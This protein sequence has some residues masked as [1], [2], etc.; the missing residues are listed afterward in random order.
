MGSIHVSGGKILCGETTIQGSKNAA[1]PLMAAAV[2]HKGM[3]VLHN[4]PV[5]QDVECMRLLLEDLGCRTG[6]EGHT[7]WIDASEI[8]K[9][10]L[11]AGLTAKMR[12][13]VLLMGALL[14]RCQEVILPFPG[15]CVIGKRPVNYHLDVM[16]RMGAEVICREDQMLLRARKLEGSETE[17]PFPSVG[18]TENGILAGTLAAGRSCLSGCAMEPEIQELCSFLRE[19]GA[20]VRMQG[21]YVSME[22]VRELHDSE[23]ILMP[24]RIVAGTYLLAVLATNGNAILHEVPVDALHVLKELIHKMG[25]GLTEYDQEKQ[26]RKWKTCTVR[27]DCRKRKRAVL[28]AETAPYPGFPTDLQSQLMAVMASCDGSTCRI[29]E[30]VFENRFMIVDQLK[31]M[32]ADIREKENEAYIYGVP[33]LHGTD[34]CVR[35]MR[36]GAALVLAAM[37]AE[38]VSRIGPED[39]IK[40]GYE[41][42]CKDLKELGADMN[43]KE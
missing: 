9:N 27:A 33:V 32:G 43:S 13:S 4:C 23:Y 31:K 22:G 42:I 11:D 40:R 34:L 30:N 17:M 39:Y 6:M 38:G 14:G 12:G 8:H 35:E 36:G 16:R 5:I 15:G 21:G 41:N 3:T 2:L 20:R 1:L 24:D 19:K 18:A 28:L 10:E 25:G 29:R 7:L 37:T 26:M